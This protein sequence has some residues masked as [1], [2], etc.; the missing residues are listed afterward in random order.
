MK[1]RLADWNRASL[2]NKYAVLYPFI[3]Q[4]DVSSTQCFGWLI[5]GS[6]DAT[7]CDAMNTL[8]TT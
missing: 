5:F 7:S 6:L 3:T 4:I 2:L 8:A 1:G